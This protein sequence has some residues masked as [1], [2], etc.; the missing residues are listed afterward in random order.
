[1]TCR[2]RRS[3]TRSTW[4]GWWLASARRR[5]PG[6]SAAV[7]GRRRRSGTRSSWRG[8]WLA[9]A[10]RRTPGS[11]AA[12]SGRRRRSGTRSTWRGW[13]LASAR[14]RT[15]GS[16]AGVSGMRDPDHVGSTNFF[17][18]IW[19]MSMV[20]FRSAKNETITPRCYLMRNVSVL[21]LL[22]LAVVSLTSF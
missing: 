1:M 3:G 5:T 2:R 10:R 22:F 11:S 13:W 16:S 21:T 6:S 18:S 19:I 14:R 7:S 9:S 8:W 20:S 4:R 12:V 15:P 17:F